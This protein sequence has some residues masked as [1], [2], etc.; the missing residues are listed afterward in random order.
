MMLMT[1]MD[2]I[3]DHKLLSAMAAKNTSRRGA[4]LNETA[5]PSQP[6]KPTFGPWA[7]LLVGVLF[8][9]PIFYP[10]KT[11]LKHKL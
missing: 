1:G 6:D 3:N 2:V 5:A 8:G 11:R 7:L 4:K 10:P 9:V